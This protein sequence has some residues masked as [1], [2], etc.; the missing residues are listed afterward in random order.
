M[1]LH[2]ALDAVVDE[3]SFMLFVKALIENRNNEVG[4]GIDEFGRGKHG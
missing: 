2:E 1:A 3:Q 4:G